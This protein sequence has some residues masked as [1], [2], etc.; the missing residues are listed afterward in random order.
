MHQ[1]E[2]KMH[3]VGARLIRNSCK[4]R[5]DVYGSYFWV[6]QVY[7]R[8]VLPPLLPRGVL[9]QSKALMIYGPS[10]YSMLPRYIEVVSEC[11]A[12]WKDYI[13]WKAYSR[14]ASQCMDENGARFIW[15]C[16]WNKF[17]NSMM[18]SMGWRGT[19][20]WVAQIG[21]YRLGG[22]AFLEDF[23]ERRGKSVDL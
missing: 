17:Q 12:G 5:P 22:I 8:Q 14:T 1:A 18:V 7:F 15:F 10:S 19:N 20:S 13:L 11:I 6:K 23:V 3:Q 2:M 9:R 16:D 4:I 21:G